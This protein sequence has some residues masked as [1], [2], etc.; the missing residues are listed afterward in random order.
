MAALVGR[1]KAAAECRAEQKHPA[2]VTIVRMADLTTDA[3]HDARRL[4]HCLLATLA[5]AAALWAIK[6]LELA[7]DL[8]LARFGVY[9]GTL[10]GL[11]GVFFAPFIHGSLGH[12]FSNTLPMVILGTALLYGYPRSAKLVIPV[13]Y[14]GTGVGVWLFARSAWHI[15]ASGL[16][17]GMMFFV[18]TSGVL[19]WD[20]RS[21]ALALVVFLLYGSM[22]WGVFPG[23]PAVS[24]ESHLAGALIGI[25]LAVLLK[26]RDPVP[27]RKR[28]SWEDEEDVDEP[29]AW[30]PE[31]WTEPGQE[32]LPP[33]DDRHRSG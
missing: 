1:Q 7:L 22:I 32:S 20:T 4:R 3:E 21:I 10:R 23:D 26:N 25:A 27:P 8:D 31:D 28:Y 13:L 14:F 33:G 11:T 6:L 29:P 9:P 5:F 18:F 12:L 30:P 17:F 15:G 2:A 16:T 24:F 19:R